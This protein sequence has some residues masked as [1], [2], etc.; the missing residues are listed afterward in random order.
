M[1]KNDVLK[2]SIALV[3]VL[4]SVIAFDA[5]YGRGSARAETPEAGTSTELRL[6]AGQKLVDVSWRCFGDYACR[7]FLLAR[8]MR[9]DEAPESY[10]LSSPYRDAND[11]YV[12]KESR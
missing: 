7:P 12:I 9:K 10:V 11:A 8:P 3:I 4:A 2:W 6:G 5:L 1:S